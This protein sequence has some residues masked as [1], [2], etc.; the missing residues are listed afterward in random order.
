R[1]GDDDFVF[2]CSV[3]S[4][5]GMRCRG[6]AEGAIG[7]ARGRA[8]SAGSRLRTSPASPPRH[9]SARYARRAP[10]LHHT[11]RLAWLRDPPPGHGPSPALQ[12]N[13]CGSSSL[14]KSGTSLVIQ[15]HPDGKLKPWVPG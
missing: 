5:S 8:L 6:A 14:L 3:S 4:M 9:A 11:T 12:K 13:V 1:V 10:L 2:H 15:Q 7:P